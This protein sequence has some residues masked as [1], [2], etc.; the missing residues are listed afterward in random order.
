M[1]FLFKISKSSKVYDF[2]I[3][4]F[5]LESIFYKKDD[6]NRHYILFS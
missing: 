4:G 2:Y 1:S 5:I 3:F 6:S